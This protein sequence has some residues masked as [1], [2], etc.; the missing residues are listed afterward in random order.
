MLSVLTPFITFWPPEH[1]AGSGVLATV[2]T[3]L[4]ISWNGLRLIGADT[5]LQGIFFW[6]FF[7]CLTK[8]MVFLVTGLQARAITAGFTS[9]SK[10]E[11]TAA[12][13]IVCAVVI[14]ARFVWMYPATYLP[15]VDFSNNCT[16][17][18]ESS[19]TCPTENSFPMSQ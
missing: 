19:E 18:R 12:A 5:R 4:Y 11:L 14:V 8:G 15:A 3:G 17:S 6:D 1:L 10:S 2:T 7:I 9:Y 13:A 16:S